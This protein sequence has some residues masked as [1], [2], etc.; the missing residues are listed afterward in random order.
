MKIAIIPS[1]N[2]P[3]PPVKGGAVQHLIKLYVDN[4]EE[5]KADRVTIFSIYNKLAEK[6][7]IKYNYTHY[8]YIK[9]SK[10]LEFFVSKDYRFISRKAFQ[11]LEQEYIS[12]ICNKLKKEKYDLILLENTPQYAPYI[13]KIL[14]NDEKIFTHLHNDY[15]NENTKNISSIIN[16]TDKF[17]CISEYIKNRIL[18][19]SLMCKTS[20]V[21]NGISIDDFVDNNTNRQKVA[22]LKRKY[23]ISSDDIVIIFSGRMVKEKGPHILIS[24]LSQMKNKKR[25]KVLL[26]GSKLYGQTIHDAFL[27]NLYDDI[28]KDKLENNIIL[29]GYVPYE[30]MPLYYKMGDIGVLPAL[31]DEPSSLTIVEY[32]KFG[33]PVVATVSGG[34]PEIVNDKCALLFYR[35]DNLSMHMANALDCLLENENLRRRMSKAGI[36]RAK[37]FTAKKIY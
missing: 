20:I 11:L 18:S 27:A 36:E 16:S 31:W 21:Y 37:E 2:L 30:E 10:S 12:L 7:S 22:D 28:H 17:I 34:I 29:T 9:L 33:L 32:L 35:D 19:S 8:E 6:E 26:L 24:A 14:R 15:V 5:F 25:C 1:I 13:K 4:N 23:N 3:M